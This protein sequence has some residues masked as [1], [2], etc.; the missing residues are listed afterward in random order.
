[1]SK[2]YIVTGAAGFLGNNIIRLLA[3]RGEKIRAFV[4][5]PGKEKNALAGLD[6]EIVYGSVTERADVERLFHNDNAEYVFIHVASV[7]D[8][9]TTKFSQK[10]HDVNVTGTKNVVDAC[11]ANGVSRFVYVSSVHAIPELPNNGLITEVESFDPALVH[12][13]YAKTKAEASAIVMEAVKGGLNAVMVHPSG[14]I[15]PNDYSNTHLT[16]LVADFA[17][18]KIPA[19]VKGGYDFVDVRDVAQSVVTACDTGDAGSRWLL[20]GNYITVA[21]LLKTL[22]ELFGRE[23]K[24]KIFSIGTAK[25]GLPFVWLWSKIT[26]KRPL[27]TRYSLYTLQSNGNFCHDKATA[28]LS[29][30]PRPLRETL[31]DTIEFLGINTK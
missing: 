11:V 29:F 23:K 13:A 28:E 20:T 25:L 10:L 21:E 16:Q 27:Y 5:S 7:V 4:N 31:T 9:G 14:I 3:A 12:G 26:R 6:A 30:V 15:G 22:G 1:M 18:G 2:I 19:G 24:L 17:A 8:I